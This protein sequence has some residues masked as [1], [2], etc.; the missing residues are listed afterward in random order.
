MHTGEADGLEW[1]EYAT[2]YGN[3]NMEAEP[4][5]VF[6]PAGES[7]NSFHDRVRRLLERL[8]AERVGPADLDTLSAIIAGVSSVSAIPCRSAAVG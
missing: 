5:R 1:G 6:A 3:F 8:A 2:K 7:W 4:D